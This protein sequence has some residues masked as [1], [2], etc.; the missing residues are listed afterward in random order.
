MRIVIAGAGS[1]GCFVGGCLAAAGREVAFLGRPRVIE[2]LLR[3]GVRLSDFDGLSIEVPPARLQARTDPEVLGS[4]DLVLVTVK[5]RDSAGMAGLIAA[6]APAGAPVVSLQNG[7]R[8]VADLRAGLPGRDVRGGMVPFNVVPGG[9]GAYHRATSG[10]IVV[11]AGSPSFVPTLSVPG[12]PVA[13]SDRI[14]AVQ[15]GK[16][17]MNL[18]NA[19]NAL[20]G[21]SLR[22]MLMDRRWRL[23][24]A[25]QMAEALAV[26][27]A[28]GRPVQSGT[29]L[30]AWLVPYILRLPTPVFARIAAS[31][32][33]I[34][35]LARTS[36][37][38]D[39]ERGR[40]T[41][42]DAL[43]GE[44]LRLAEANGLA[45]PV[46][47]RVRAAILAAEADGAGTTRP[48]PEALRKG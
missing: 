35:P 32:L 28:T 44:I 46:T 3:A 31:M 25:D 23:L 4:A 27:R 17:I 12:L 21:Q 33:T 40:P 5:T 30:P 18:T 22:D 6:H 29:P 38:Y 47:S 7:I 9:D 37:A 1:I 10:D 8:A 15:W 13:E 24:L 11:E 36:M 41:E 48:T 20:S 34:D 16:L 43:Q 19:P 26:L 42:I 14:E 2:D 45:A 39:L